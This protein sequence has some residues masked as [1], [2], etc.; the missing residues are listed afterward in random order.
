MSV[1]EYYM[2]VR[3]AEKRI[4][5]TKVAI[6]KA[7]EDYFIAEAKYRAGAGV[8]LDVIDAQ[9]ALTTARNNYIAAQHDYVTYKAQLENAMGMD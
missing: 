2:G 5:T 3:E 8:M 7:E 6:H 4:A 1:K 9:L